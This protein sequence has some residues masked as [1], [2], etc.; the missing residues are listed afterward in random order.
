MREWDRNTHA[1]VQ[2]GL[3]TTFSEREREREEKR[4]KGYANMHI[5]QDLFVMLTYHIIYEQVWKCFFISCTSSSTDMLHIYICNITYTNIL[6]NVGCGGH[7]SRCNTCS[8]I[9]HVSGGSVCRYTVYIHSCMYECMCTYI[10]RR[11]ARRLLCIIR[12]FVCMFRYCVYVYTYT[13]VHVCIYYKYA[14]TQ[15][16][17]VC[18]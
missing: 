1:Y 5:R 12:M 6:F 2:V 11:L 4:E 10:H 14:S 18:T 3:F 15:N 8:N 9:F 16:M 7:S 13:F 17:S